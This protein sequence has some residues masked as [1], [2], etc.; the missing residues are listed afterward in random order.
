MGVGAEDPQDMRA[1]DRQSFPLVV[2]PGGHLAFWLFRLLKWRI[3]PVNVFAPFIGTTAGGGTMAGVDRRFQCTVACT[4]DSRTEVV[5]GV[6]ML[7]SDNPFLLAS[8]LICMYSEDAESA[9]I[10]VESSRT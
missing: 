7:L 2:Q 8:C 3:D 4:I 5:L 10:L 6:W 9:A 1:P